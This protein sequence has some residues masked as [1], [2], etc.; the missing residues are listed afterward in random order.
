[1]LKQEVK[2]K[3]YTHP[4]IKKMSIGEQYEALQAFEEILK[5]Q[6]EERPYESV[7][8]LFAG[9]YDESQF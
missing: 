7:S 5:S 1:M 8:E 4:A 6:Q 3:F 9:S 2:E